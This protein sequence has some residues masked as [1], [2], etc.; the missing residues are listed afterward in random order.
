MK[1]AQVR[2]DKED[3]RP[4]RFATLEIFADHSDRPDSPGFAEFRLSSCND[5]ADFEANRAACASR[6]GH[7]EPTSVAIMLPAASAGTA[8]TVT[9]K[10]RDSNVSRLKE[11]NA[12]LV[13]LGG[14]AWPFFIGGAITCIFYALIYRGPLNLPV[15]HRY[16]TA[17][18]GVVRRDVPVLRRLGVVGDEDAG[19]A[20]PVRDLAVVTRWASADRGGAAG[21]APGQLLERLARLPAPARKSYLGRRLR[22][23]LQF[24]QPK[25]TPADGL[26]GRTEVPLRP[27]R[28]RGS[29]RV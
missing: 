8:H 21:R 12:F 18:S 6:C 4:S 17:Q 3:Y 27:G 25:D 10:E 20:G 23:A 26:D 19:R 13:V 14:L 1:A 5:G 24:V 22:D 28:R 7:A 16:F 15:M 11:R 2:G 9:S 29:R